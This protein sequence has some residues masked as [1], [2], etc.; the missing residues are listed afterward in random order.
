MMSTSLTYL[1]WYSV[2]PINLFCSDNHHHYISNKTVKPQKHCVAKCR[3][4]VW[5]TCI[6]YTFAGVLCNNI[7][8]LL[9]AVSA[10][11]KLVTL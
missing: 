6:G 11:G 9:I 3:D 2:F 10:V 1:L 8:I 7:I 4:S 5:F